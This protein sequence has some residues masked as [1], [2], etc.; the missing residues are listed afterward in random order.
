MDCQ[1]LSFDAK[2]SEQR[3]EKAVSVLGTQIVKRLIGFALYLMGVN[4]SAVA[5]KLGIPRDTAKSFIK[6]VL[7][8]G[9]AAFEDRRRRQR[10]AP[11]EPEP[12]PA[13]VVK[14]FREGDW[15]VAQFG[16]GKQSLRIPADNLLQV[17]SVL[18]SMYS[19]GLITAGDASR[20][21]GVTAVHVRNM[22]RRLHDGD[23][24]ALIDKR[25]GQKQDYVVTSQIKGEL[26]QQFVVE[27]LVYGKTSGRKLAEELCRRRQIKVAERT[28]RHHLSALGLQ[29]IRKTLPELFETVKKTPKPGTEHG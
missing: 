18:L 13:P 24:S 4:R 19:S 15:I 22:A 2:L 9:L 1:D 27:L 10:F 14:L 3:M 20:Q 21:L 6:T 16:S 28:V 8:D 5:R 12:E 25:Q 29:Q 11:S 26:I 7:K 17:R 23:V